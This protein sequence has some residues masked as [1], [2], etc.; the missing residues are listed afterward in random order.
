MNPGKL[1]LPRDTTSITPDCD[2]TP[3]GYQIHYFTSG[4]SSSGKTILYIPGGPGQIVNRDPK[5][6]DLQELESMFRIV[7]FDVRGAGLSAPQSAVDNS[8]DRFLRANYVVK[9]M[10]EIRKQVLLDEPWDAI[11]G[12]SAGSVFAQMYAEQFGKITPTNSKVRVKTVI[13]SAPIS[14]HIDNEPFRAALIVTNLKNILENNT[15]PDCPW[16]QIDES[17]IVAMLNRARRAAARLVTWFVF[18]PI[19]FLKSTNN[20]CFLDSTRIENITATLENKLNLIVLKYGS[21]SFVLENHKGLVS[22]DKQFQKEFPY[23]EKF[24]VALRTLDRLG[25]PKQ[26]NADLEFKARSFQVDA[27]LVVGYYLDSPTPQDE[28]SKEC[29]PQARFFTTLFSDIAGVY[30]RRF[31]EAAKI[32]ASVGTHRSLRAANV[33]GIREGIH[34]WPVRL[35]EGPAHGCNKERQFLEFANDPA[36][37]NTTA[38]KLLSKVGFETTQEICAWDPARFKHSVPAL[39]LKGS[40]DAATHGCQAEHFFKAG[41]LSTNK[42]FI[43]FLELGHDWISEIKPERTG[44]LRTLVEKFINDP[45]QFS[46]NGD[47][48]QALSRLGAISRTAASFAALPC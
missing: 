26:K 11:Y 27:A 7:Y 30:C 46:G 33:L 20:F 5:L 28:T 32:D 15:D 22:G 14:R 39:I 47:V 17:V 1:T 3:C 40:M 29:N 18:D 16:K 4:P 35:M 44:D 6:R 31:L 41:F 12:H 34:R 25:S 38:K 23:P 2:G 24:F 9:D 48:K 10:E 43:E 36:N 21:I 37:S 8:S 13:L 42:V 19:K 45:P